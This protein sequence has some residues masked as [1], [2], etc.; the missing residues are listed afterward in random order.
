MQSAR[1]SPSADVVV[2][3]S[4]EVFDGSRDR[5]MSIIGQQHKPVEEFKRRKG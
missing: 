5:L 4:W 1:T 2:C 3:V